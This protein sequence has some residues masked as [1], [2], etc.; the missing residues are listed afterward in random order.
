MAKFTLTIETD[1]LSELAPFVTGQEAARAIEAK[2]EKA[3]PGRKPKAV[4]E[5][6]EPV[7]QETAVPVVEVKAE[8]EETVLPL[9]EAVR[10]A[11]Q[12]RKVPAPK[13]LD[14]IKSEGFDSLA[15]VPPEHQDRLSKIIQA[16]VA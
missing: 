15:A 4:E 16:L 8:P 7:E 1:D 11:I 14:V 3:K 6:P 10:R 5:A 13:V 2:P 12:E 9:Q